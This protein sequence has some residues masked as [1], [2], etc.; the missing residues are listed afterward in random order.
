M[1]LERKTDGN[2]E[3]RQSDDSSNVRC[4]VIRS[5]KNIEELMDMLGIKESLDRTA[6]VASRMQWDGQVL[7]KED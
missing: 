5:K 4:E 3:N 1:V 2:F 6:K 7:R